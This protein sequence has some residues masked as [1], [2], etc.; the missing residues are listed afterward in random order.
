TTPPQF[1]LYALDGTWPIEGWGV[2]PDIVVVNVPNDVVAGQDAQLDY[3]I[4]YLLKQLAASNGK[5]DVP[6]L[7]SYP[8]KAK[9]RMSK[10]QY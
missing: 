4:E 1:G 6:A 3:A 8:N 2:E 9:P 7:P 10:T 5:W